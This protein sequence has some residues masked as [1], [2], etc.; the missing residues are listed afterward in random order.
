MLPA[1]GLLGLH[2]GSAALFKRPGSN[3]SRS[4]YGTCGDAQDYGKG[5]HQM[6]THDMSTPLMM[7]AWLNV[8]PL[9]ARTRLFLSVGGFNESYSEI[10]KLG[11]GY[12]AELTARIVA[13]GADAALV[14]P[15]RHTYFRNGCGGK[16]TTATR[17]KQRQ[18]HV[19][20]EANE[21]TF[22]RQFE[23][24]EAQLLARVQAA[25]RALER[26]TSALMAL[27]RLFPSCIRCSA[28]GDR[29]TLVHLF[30]KADQICKDRGHLK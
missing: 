10:G 23:A 18:R 29:E 6:P 8:G 12:D 21:R 11:I 9:V 15:S 1:L 19:A 16:A 5:W 27:A 3:A 22:T 2:R 17:S 4:Y 24:V 13:S 20:M 7:A 25:Q 14:C 28:R 26:N 30:H